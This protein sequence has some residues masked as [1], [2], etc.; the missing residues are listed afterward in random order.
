MRTQTIRRRVAALVFLGLFISP[1]CL[2]QVWYVGGP[3]W[4]YWLSS[5]L[6]YSQLLVAG[7]LFI[8]T[9]RRFRSWLNRPIKRSTDE[10]DENGSWGIGLHLAAIFMGTIFVLISL[11]SFWTI[12]SRFIEECKPLS[13]CF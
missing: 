6:C 7:L 8:L 2:N 12:T 3:G 11:F 13:N 1:F 9:P 5:Y 4:M 10:G